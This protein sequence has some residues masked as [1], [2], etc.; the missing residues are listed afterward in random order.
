MHPSWTNKLKNFSLGFPFIFSWTLY[1]LTGYYNKRIAEQLEIGFSDS[2][3]IPYFYPILPALRLEEDNFL[4]SFSLSRI[5]TSESFFDFQNL[6][7]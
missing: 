7:F 4:L 1:R 3:A 2:S 6:Y 5:D